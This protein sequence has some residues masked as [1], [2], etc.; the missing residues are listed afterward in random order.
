MSL[1]M[2]SRLTLTLLFLIPLITAKSYSAEVDHFSLSHLDVQDSTKLIE[3][4]INR[5]M[6]VAIDQANRPIKKVMPKHSSGRFPK[7]PGCNETRLYKQLKWQLARPVVGQLETF[8]EESAHISKRRVPFLK[9][10]YQDFFWQESPSLVLSQRMA[11]IIKINNVEIGTDKLGHFFTEGLSYFDLTNK[12]T[13]DINLGLHFGR[14]TESLYFGAQTT[15]VFSYADLTANFNGLRYWNKILAKQ[16][17]PLTHQT[18]TPYISCQ[19]KKWVVSEGFSFEPYID[20][21]WNEQINC[22]LYRN[23]QLLDKAKRHQLSCLIKKLPVQKYSALPSLLNTKGADVLP[24]ELQPESLVQEKAELEKTSLSE[25]TT[26][27]IRDIR[28][29]IEEWR[30]NAAKKAAL[31]LNTV[32]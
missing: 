6:T 26:Q 17:D 13:A 25:Q 3:N 5:L 21:A 23:Q 27:R 19:D 32:N 18:V 16:Q 2:I 8:A 31:K 14:W 12:L 10:I 9:S 11:A 22:S 24:T 1:S 20:L 29:A 28:I 30:A 4:E 7:R 15:G